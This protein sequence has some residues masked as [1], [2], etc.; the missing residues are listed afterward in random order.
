MYLNKLKLKSFR[1]FDEAKVTLPFFA[2]IS[3]FYTAYHP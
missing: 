1:S 2:S 3:N